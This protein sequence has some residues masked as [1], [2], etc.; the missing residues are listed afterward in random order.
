MTRLLL[1][2]VLVLTTALPVAAQQ[3]WVNA[4]HTLTGVQQSSVLVRAAYALRTYLGLINDGGNV[5]YCTVDGATAVANTG[6]RLA[7]AGTTGDRI[8]FDAKV[9]QGAVRCIAATGYN[10][11]LVIEGR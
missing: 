4:H 6:I 2:L 9:P 8:F 5:V 10:V 11:I 1:A 3:W 7:A